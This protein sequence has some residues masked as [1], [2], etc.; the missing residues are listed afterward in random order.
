MYIAVAAVAFDYVS[1]RRSAQ[2]RYN[3]ANQSAR[4]AADNVHIRSMLID[5]RLLHNVNFDKETNTSIHACCTWEILRFITRYDNRQRN[6][7]Q[8]ILI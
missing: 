3:R 4:T 8:P 6:I 2:S 1:N 7:M 5:A